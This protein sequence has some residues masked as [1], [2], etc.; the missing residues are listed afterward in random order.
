MSSKG[1]SASIPPKCTCDM[2]HPHT[3]EMNTECCVNCKN[4]W[5]G[6][7]PYE[8]GEFAWYCNNKGCPCHQKSMNTEAELR[9]LLKREYMRG[10][11]NRSNGKYSLESLEKRYQRYLEDNPS[12]ETD[13]ASLLNKHISNK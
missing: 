7:D 10:Q 13:I 2:P 6:S 12:V 1:W 5:H 11:I 9:K 3:E 8:F 4:T